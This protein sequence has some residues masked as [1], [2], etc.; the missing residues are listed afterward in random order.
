M[1]KKKYIYVYLSHCI[2]KSFFPGGGG[3]FLDNKH[4]DKPKIPGKYAKMGKWEWLNS[5]NVM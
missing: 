4:S 3:S 5:K 2:I 1:I